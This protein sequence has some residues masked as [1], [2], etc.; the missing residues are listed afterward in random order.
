MAGGVACL[1]AVSQET[2]ALAD[3]A[4]EVL[5]NCAC[6]DVIGWSVA[7]GEGRIYFRRG[8]C[9]IWQPCYQTMI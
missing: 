6:R 5:F 2:V 8:G 1:L 4:G 9:P 3:E 7:R